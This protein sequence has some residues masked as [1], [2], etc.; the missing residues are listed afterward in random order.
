M[1]RKQELV[2]YNDFFPH[3]TEEEESRKVNADSIQVL[4]KN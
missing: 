2:W 3:V 4:I 1:S